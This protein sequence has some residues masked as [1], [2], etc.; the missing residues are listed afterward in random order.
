[1]SHAWKSELS[2]KS[3]KELSGIQQKQ[4]GKKEELR[5]KE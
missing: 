2:C 3:A 1:V 5:E 4:E